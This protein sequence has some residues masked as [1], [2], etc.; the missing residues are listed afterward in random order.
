MRLEPYNEDKIVIQSEQQEKK[1]IKIIGQQRKIP[2][3]TLFELNTE[4]G[5]IK[6]A[7][8]AKQDLALTSLSSVESESVIRN[9]VNANDN[10]MYIQALNHKNA[11]KKFKKWLVAFVHVKNR[12]NAQNKA[13]LHLLRA[14]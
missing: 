9:R 7:E 8:F 2:G 6:E 3:L 1:Q 13:W 12:T 4:T 5:E 14:D 10:C 11:A